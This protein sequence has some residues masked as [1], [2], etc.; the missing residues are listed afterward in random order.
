MTIV[1]LIFLSPTQGDGDS[2]WVSSEDGSSVEIDETQPHS[3]L[4]IKTYEGKRML[5]K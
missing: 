1:I 3:T 4:Q 2:A 5:I